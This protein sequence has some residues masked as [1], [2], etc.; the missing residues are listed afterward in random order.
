M[1][2]NVR[3]R[4][5]A[6]LQEQDSPSPRAAKK[7]K[8]DR[9]DL[10]KRVLCKQASKRAKMSLFSNGRFN[11]HLTV[12]S[13]FGGKTSRKD[14]SAPVRSE[15]THRSSVD[16]ELDLEASFASTMS[17]NSPVRDSQPLT[18][19]EENPNYV[20]MDISPAP[21]RIS[22]PPAPQPQSTSQKSFV[23]RPRAATSAARLFG[24]DMSNGHDSSSPFSGSSVSKSGNGTSSGK[25]LQRSALPFEWTGKQDARQDENSSSQV[26]RSR[27]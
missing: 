1:S 7:Q 17:L 16:V 4:L 27:P 9:P 26:R 13:F 22:Q 2:L 25:R 14:A 11:G 12:P 3:R 10:K 20:P 19:E 6:E 5:F 8:L 18:P 15:T 21:H 23:G 24:H